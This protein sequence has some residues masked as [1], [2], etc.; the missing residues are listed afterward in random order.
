MSK[1]NVN[2][3]KN[4]NNNNDDNNHKR[5]LLITFYNKLDTST[6]VGKHFLF[7]CLPVYGMTHVHKKFQRQVKRKLTITK[8]TKKWTTAENGPVLSA[9]TAFS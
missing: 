9:L 2:Q 1:T 8:T 5:D 4:N 3:L 7:S 6:Q